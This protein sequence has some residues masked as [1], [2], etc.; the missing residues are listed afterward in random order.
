M[1]SLSHLLET[2]QASLQRHKQPIFVTALHSITAADFIQRVATLRAHIEQRAEQRWLLWLPELSDFA[3][4][5]FALWHAG[6]TPILPSNFQPQMLHELSDAYDAV[7]H[8]EENF[9][10]AAEQLRL[11]DYA[12]STGEKKFSTLDPEQCR[13]VLYTSGSTDRPKAVSKSL[14]QLDAEIHVLEQLWGQECADKPVLG[15]VPHHHIY[16]LLFRLLWPLASGRLIMTALAATPT[17]M[18]CVWHTQGQCVLISSPTHLS[19]FPDLVDLSA[20][21]GRY[22]MVFSS[23]A[24]FPEKPARMLAHAWGQPVQE[25][26]GSSET[27]GIAW[28]NVAQA[29]YPGWVALPGVKVGLSEAGTLQIRSPFLPDRALYTTADKIE[30]FAD[31]SFTLCGR[32]DRVIKIEGKRVSL[33]VVENQLRQH[34]WVQHAAVL[35]LHATRQRL[36]A[37]VVLTSQ[38]AMILQ[39]G[40][41][42]VIQELRRTLGQSMD[43]VLVP[44]RWRFVEQMPVDARGKLPLQNLLDLFK[45]EF[46]PEHQTSS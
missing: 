42:L 31:G 14:V 8:N 3:V 7:L 27:G 1:V 9:S 28:R 12:P 30:L 41:A 19:R 45:P 22:A 24:P 23:G 43:A 13:L 46:N 6:R 15:T 17:E 2:L 10:C 37:V 16:G 18:S 38:G 4:A 11:A 35:A 34:P 20:W 26:Y 39:Q 32:V 44:R 5:L 40:R 25:V 21:S 33:D 29:V 36:A